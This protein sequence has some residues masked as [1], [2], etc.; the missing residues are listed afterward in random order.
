MVKRSSNSNTIQQKLEAL[1]QQKLKL[2][3]QRD[4]ELLG[5]LHKTN[6]H[7]MDLFALTGALLE[8]QKTVAAN[9]SQAESWRQ[10][11]EMFLH[12]KRTARAETHKPKI[13]AIP[14][15]KLATA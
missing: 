9:P 6:A 1:Q 11:G 15:P 12:P 3:A 8:I 10:A 13:A 4:Q 14:T 2:E 5:I 7:R